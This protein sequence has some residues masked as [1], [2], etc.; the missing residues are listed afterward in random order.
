MG[1]VSRN[2]A[3]GSVH[4]QAPCRARISRP[5]AD[6]AK[7]P[8]LARADCVSR[9]TLAKRGNHH[10]DTWKSLAVTRK[11]RAFPF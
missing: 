4:H 11:E 7:T 8:R 1:G 9:L 3:P 5:R 10:R 6:F 2:R